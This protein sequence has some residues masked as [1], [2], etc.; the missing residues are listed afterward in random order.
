MAF[1]AS[2]SQRFSAKNK[3]DLVAQQKESGAKNLFKIFTG[4]KTKH[5]VKEE[6][7]EVA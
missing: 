3:L 7:I 2:G 5:E 4:S 1:N 6:S